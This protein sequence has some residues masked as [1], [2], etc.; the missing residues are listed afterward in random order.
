MIRRSTLVLAALACALVPPALLAQS[1]DSLMQG[2]L[3]PI[4]V[5]AT[6][7]PHQLEDVP[8]PTEVVSRAEIDARGAARLPDLLAEQTGLMLHYD[9]GTGIQMQG[10]G[11]EYTSILVDGVRLIGRTAGTLELNRITLNN[12]QRI[13]VIR[14]PSSSLYGSESLAGVVNIITATPDSLLEGTFRAR[15]G[16]HESSDVSAYVGRRNGPYSASLFINRYASDGYDL[17]PSTITPT[18]PA[19]SDYTAQTRLQARFQSG[20]SLHLSARGNLQRQDNPLLVEVDDASIRMQ[21]QSDQLDWNVAPSVTQRLGSSYLLTGRAYV[22]RFSNLAE[23]RRID[24]RNVYSS[25]DYAQLYSEAET[26]LEGYP[27]AKHYV[28][29]GAGY[30]HETVDADRVEG[31]RGTFYAFAQDEWQAFDALDVVLS[32]RFDAPTDYAARLSPKA[33]VLYRPFEKWRVRLSVGSGYKAPAFRQLYLDFTNAT[34]GYTVLGATEVREGLE[35]LQDEGQI[36]EVLAED[37]ESAPLDSESSWAYNAEV[38]YRPWPGWRAKIGVFRN[39]VSNLIDT[40]PIAVKNNGQHVFSYFNLTEVYTRGIEAVLALRLLSSLSVRLG[41]QFLDTGDRKVLDRIDAGEM[42]TRVDGRDRLLTR[43]EYGGLM[44][45]SRHQG[46]VQLLYTLDQFGLTA[47]LTSRL[48]S[49][50]GLA[51]V[52]GNG[53]LDVD[54][55]YVDGYGIWNA[56]LSKDLD[57]FTVRFGV[58]NFTSVRPDHVPALSGARWFGGVEFKL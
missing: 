29:G 57:R 27:F 55:E 28:M 11:P 37:L 58:D 44:Q 43:D 18:G 34:A 49:R 19:Y 24:D 26:T 1:S 52:N 32:T 45:R 6:R 15:Y 40:R 7:T 10:L 46:T 8:I 54:S 16:T 42:Y 36:A 56:T 20:T 48:R 12:V 4:V 51:D 41:Y 53:V 3:D 33:A 25:S 14:G 5:T 31:S 17:D 23:T 30:I 2:E 39:D 9:H 47:V 13:E 22:S 21:D 38:S 50:Y 35:R